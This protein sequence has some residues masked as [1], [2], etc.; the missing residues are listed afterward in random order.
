MTEDP[1][2]KKEEESSGT[3]SKEELDEVLIE[4]RFS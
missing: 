3:L 2:T 1:E 4:L